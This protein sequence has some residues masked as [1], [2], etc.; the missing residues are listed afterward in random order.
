MRDLF[1]RDVGTLR[2]WGVT[3]RKAVCDFDTTPPDTSLSG[4]PGNP[5]NET[6]PSFGFSSPDP[7]ATF[8]CSLDSGAYEPCSSPKTYTGVGEAPSPHVFR[9]RAVDGS[10]N[11]DATPAQYSWVVDTTAPATTIASGPTQ[12]SSVGSNA[13]NFTFTSE[14]QARFECKLDAGAFV[15]C[16]DP[17]P[18]SYTGLSEGSHTFQVRAIDLA[19]NADATPASRTWTVDTTPPA[20]AVTAPAGPTEDSTPTLSGT[21]EP[22]ALSVKVYDGSGHS[23]PP[24]GSALLHTLSPV[25]GSGGSW[26]VDVPASLGLGPYTVQAEQTDAAGN[27]GRSALSVFTVVT[28]AVAPVVSLTAPASGAVLDDTTPV[29]AGLAGLAAGDEGI[30]SVKL[31]SGTLAAGL[32]AQT[33]VVPRDGASGAFSAV[34]AALPEGTYTVRAEQSDSAAPTPNTGMSAPVTFTVSLPEPPPPPPPAA[35]APGFVIAPA[36]ERLSDALAGRYTATAACVSACQVTARLSVSATSARRLGLTARSLA[37]GSGIKRLGSAGTAAVR[38]RL[39]RSAKAALRR[40]SVTRASL[41]LTIV[42]GDQTQRLS[43]SVALRRDAGLRR[44]ASRGLSLWTICS[45]AC[46]LS[47]RMTVSAAAARKLGLK[48]SGRGRV[49]IGAGRTSAGTSPKQLRLKVPARMRRALGRARKV[50]ALVEATA[51]TAPNP[52][53]SARRSLTLRR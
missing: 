15:P 13:A 32:P 44:F 31:W 51:G 18:Q 48:V 10:D 28:D 41:T 49:Q 36:E 40:R 50:A 3:S 4:F 6:S 42:D 45:R 23:D 34:P 11:E 26:S 2:A 43:R 1:E 21:A 46:P 33:L 7:G 27:L 38:V 5:T 35:L 53:R 22:G 37:I 29:L 12:G 16:S 39:S 30:V 14:A 20:P 25:A 17:Q 19:D 8:E 24:S 47:A 9:V 52:R